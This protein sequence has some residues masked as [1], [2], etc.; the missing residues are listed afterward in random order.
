MTS[1]RWIF[2]PN[3]EAAAQV[4]SAELD[5]PEI[6]ARVLV[7][8]G[9]GQAAQAREFMKSSLEQCHSPWLLSGMKTGIQRTRQ[10]LQERQKIVIFGDYDVDGV[11]STTI[12]IKLFKLLGASVEYY[13][14]D[15]LSEGYGPSRGAFEKLRRSGASLI[16]T[17]DCG[18]NAVTEIAFAKSLGLDVIVTDHHVPGAS[19]P[20]AIAVINPKTSPE[21]PY[22]MLG[23]VGVAYKF[24]Q[25]LLED[26]GEARKDEFLD[27]MLEMVALGTVCDVAPLDGENRALVSAGIQR[28][29]QGRWMGLRSLCKAAGIE[30][31]AID[32]GQIGF[33]LG[34]RLNAGGRVNK[35]AL[36]VE[37]LL[38]KDPE[39]CRNLA[40]RLNDENRQRQD[41]EKEVLASAMEQAEIRIKSGD[42]AL[43]LWNEA[44]HPGVIGLAASRIQEKFARPCIVISTKDGLGKGSGR[45][46]R[47]FHLVKALESASSLLLKFGGHEFAAGLTIESRH[48]EAFRDLMNQVAL[49]MLGAEPRAAELELDC[50][51]KFSEINSTLM[52][53]LAD[54]QPF[55]LKNPRPLFGA[56]A[57]ILLPGT[58]AVGADGSHLKLSLRQGPLSFDGIAFRQAD[59]LKVLDIKR[60]VDIAFSP[61]WNEYNGNR[62]LQLDVKDMVQ[63]S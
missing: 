27:T 36:G 55:G 2:R 32:S 41:I 21:Y 35:A 29:K 6:L 47:P 62:S 31:S 54:L 63:S 59:L 58:R 61:D 8:R 22:D 9:M 46:R 4:L 38:S 49:E 34:P 3:N 33:A 56:K 28:L 45:C 42:R 19:L 11:T 16:I 17:V 18:I 60:P 48:L 50:W 7:A 24:T 37:L 14:P 5:V 10:A 44:W 57:C 12:L 15:R 40:Q 26:L 39:E 52:K 25:A 20:E 13:I 43:V 51:S 1:K 30:S 53:H 23:G